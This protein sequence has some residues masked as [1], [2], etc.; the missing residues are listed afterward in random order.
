MEFGSSRKGSLLN[1]YFLALFFIK[2]YVDCVVLVKWNPIKSKKEKSLVNFFYLLNKW[3]FDVEHLSIFLMDYKHNKQSIFHNLNLLEKKKLGFKK[4]L[5]F[6][7]KLIY[8]GITSQQK[9]IAM[10]L[11][12]L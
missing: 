3:L 7:F 6:L 10:V 11:I 9:A 12:P 2:F 5:F 4:A 8:L 1:V